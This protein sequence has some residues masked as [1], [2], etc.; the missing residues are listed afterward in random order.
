MPEAPPPSCIINITEFLERAKSFVHL[1]KKDELLEGIQELK[2]FEK[3]WCR[4]RGRQ[5]YMQNLS[6]H[7]RHSDLITHVPGSQRNFFFL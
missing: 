6:H 4:L 5:G 2:M 1:V 3:E 7:E